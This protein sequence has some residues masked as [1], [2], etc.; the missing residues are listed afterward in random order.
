MKLLE[1]LTHRSGKSHF[2][3][4]F[5][6]EKLEILGD[7][8]LD[9]VTNSNLMRF[10][11]FERYLE[12]PTLQSE[13]TEMYKFGEDFSCADAHQAKCQL[14]KNEILAK[15]CVLMGLHKYIIYFDAK[16]ADEISKKDVE[17]YL[18]YSF[19]QTNF[20]LNENEIEPFEAPKI[21]GDIFESVMGAIFDDGGLN[22]V[23]KVYKHLLTPFILF[24][25]KF[26]KE[27]HKEPKEIFIIK[28]TMDY[29]IRPKFQLQDVPQ[30][31]EVQ[32]KQLVNVHSKSEDG[33][34]STKEMLMPISTMA[35][36][37]T[38]DVLWR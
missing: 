10:T 31:M 9:Y 28:A 17:D 27:V 37:Y 5:N 30:I 7:A 22:A 20:D 13:Q 16:N 18:K 38:C 26:S 2:F 14:V 34:E 11:L 21:L 24:V 15:L 35:E 23:M 32:G 33:K 25:A 3:L 6:Y 36:M 19:V 8:I 1:A 4:P 29:R 12:D